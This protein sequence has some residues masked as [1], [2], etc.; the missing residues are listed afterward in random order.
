MYNQCSLSN[1]KVIEHFFPSIAC[2]SM[3]ESNKQRQV[4]NSLAAIQRA[5]LKRA[6]E[7]SKNL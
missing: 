3:I 2:N 5:K 1:K 7:H 6:H 4:H